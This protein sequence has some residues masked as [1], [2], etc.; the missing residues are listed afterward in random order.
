MIVLETEWPPWPGEKQDSE[1]EGR[2]W[3]RSI[4]VPREGWN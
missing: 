3:V 1:S 2:G 4:P